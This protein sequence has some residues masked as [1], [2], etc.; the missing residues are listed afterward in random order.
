MPKALFFNVPGHG[1]IYP[2]LPLVSELARRGHQ[3]RYYATPAFQETIEAT[4]AEFHA[5]PGMADEY[6]TGRGLHG[7]ELNRVRLALMESTRDLLPGLI[8]AVRQTGPDYILYDGMCPWGYYLAR[9]LGL[10][11]VVSYALLPPVRPPLSALLDVKLVGSLLP[12]LLKDLGKGRQANQFAASLGR[13]YQVK[14]LGATN[15]LGAPGD[16]GFTYTSREFM[17]FAENVAENIHFIGWTRPLAA[18]TKPSMLAP[19][20]NRRLIYVSLGTLNNQDFEFFQECIK[21]LSGEGHYIILSTGGRINPDVFSPLPENSAVYGWVPQAAVLERADLFIS[22][23]GLN[24]VH[25]SLYLGVPLLLVPQQ[26]E[27]AMNA[28]RVVELGAGMMLEKR[29]FSDEALRQKTHILLTDAS[30]RR[31]AGRIGES[32]R[33]AGGAERAADIL[34]DWLAKQGCAEG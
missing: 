9:H 16:I 3:I 14:A 29:Q 18:E 6:F 20:G 31:S 13:T 12:A 8:K 1:H 30:Y 32:F 17:P 23:G 34:E 26:A 15:M 10:P 5:Y 2:S 27:Q 28:R 24:S 22:H 19:I 4:G 11:A 33:Q 25:D 7:G 21:A